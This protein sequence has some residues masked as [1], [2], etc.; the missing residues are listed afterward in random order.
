MN[1]R[2]YRLAQEL[3]V[4]ISKVIEAASG[5]GLKARSALTMLSGDN[6]QKIRD[7]V[8]NS[9]VDTHDSTFSQ[10]DENNL[11]NTTKK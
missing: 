4:P 1:K 8:T 2:I 10:T 7:R 11:N 9:V 3:D 6:I 5:L